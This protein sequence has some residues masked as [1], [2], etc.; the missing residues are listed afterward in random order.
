MKCVEAC[1]QKASAAS[2]PRSCSVFQFQKLEKTK[3][4]SEVTAN[5]GRE[6]ASDEGNRVQG[7]P[8]VLKI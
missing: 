2:F 7:S 3:S 4:G 5:G 8:F 6:I 1:R